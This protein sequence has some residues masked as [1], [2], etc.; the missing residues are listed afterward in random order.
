MVLFHGS[1]VIV[2]NPQIMING[3]YKDFGYGFYC[4]NIERQARRWAL[5]KRKKHVINKYQYKKTDDSK[6]QI[7]N[8]STGFLYRKGTSEPDIRRELRAMSNM[9][10]PDEEITKNDLYFICYMIERVA[11]KL[12]QR[13]A[14]VANK[15]GKE[16]LTRL[17]SLA[18]VLHCENP[19][20]VEEEWIQEYELEQ[21]THHILDVDEDL[22]NNP[23]TATQMGKVYTRLITDT[24]LPEEDYIEGLLRIYNDSICQ[25]IDNYNSSAYY[26]PS[27]VIARA[28]N[29]GGFKKQGVYQA[30][31]KKR[32]QLIKLAVRLYQ[33]INYDISLVRQPLFSLPKDQ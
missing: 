2:Q 3:F 33:R 30:K 13:N 11:R 19:L 21:G 31:G 16:E 8:A 25:V 9:F 7:S 15:I 22:V 5:T 17:I 4:T 6:I 27:Y 20:K 14:Y 23:P 29:N 1:N 10:F 32:P 26:E 12:H 24:R 18:N 28:Y